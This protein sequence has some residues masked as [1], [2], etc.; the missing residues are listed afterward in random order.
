M[1]SQNRKIRTSL[2]WVYGAGPQ[3]IGPADRPSFGWDTLGVGYWNLDISVSLPWVS[4]E[5]IH[6][7]M[8]ISS[9]KCS[10]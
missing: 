6:L 3:R 5:L 9:M 8:Y 4:D 10:I 7:V 1:A 2:I